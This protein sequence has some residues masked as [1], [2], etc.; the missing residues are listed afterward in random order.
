MT[1]AGTGVCALRQ[2]RKRR[3]WLH[4]SCAVLK[5]RSLVWLAGQNVRMKRRKK[6]KKTNQM[7]LEA[8]KT[9]IKLLIERGKAWSSGGTEAVGTY[10]TV[11]SSGWV[12]C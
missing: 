8:N 4:M 12:Y 3:G 6:N 1:T 7:C 10:C 5:L 9:N 11:V 2:N